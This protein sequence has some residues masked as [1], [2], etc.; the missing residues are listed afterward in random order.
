MSNEV[1]QI[2]HQS[3]VA[4]MIINQKVIYLRDSGMSHLE[5]YTSLN[6][7][8]ESFDETIRGYYKNGK[9][10]FYKGDFLYDDEVIKTAEYYGDEIK[11]EVNDSNALVY[12]G[13][14]KGK[15]GEV[16]EPIIQIKTKTR[17]R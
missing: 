1:E 4:F 11:K 17:K 12:A 16:W 7:P 10:I 3:R 13:V 6:L 2:F 8:V 15:I 9:I 5:W 14:K